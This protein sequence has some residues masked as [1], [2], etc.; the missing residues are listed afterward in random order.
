MECLGGKVE[1]ERWGGEVAMEILGWG[2]EVE[3]ERCGGGD[4][5]VD[6]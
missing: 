5:E 3:M 1:L 2:G 6:R 4:G